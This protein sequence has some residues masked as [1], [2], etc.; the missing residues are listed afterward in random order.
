MENGHERRGTHVFRFLEIPVEPLNLV[1]EILLT[2][3]WDS[4]DPIFHAVD[5]PEMQRCRRFTEYW[6]TWAW[7]LTDAKKENKNRNTMQLRSAARDSIALDQHSA[8]KPS[9]LQ[10]ENGH[11]LREKRVLA[12][13]WEIWP[14]KADAAPMVFALW[15]G[16]L[17][18]Q[19]ISYW[20]C[21]ISRSLRCNWRH[22]WICQLLLNFKYWRPTMSEVIGR[23]CSA[24]W[25]PNTV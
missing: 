25:V 1:Y 12:R 3:D 11:T 24:I 23:R 4:N 16:L 19:T 21:D 22:C 10:W 2:N 13:Y 14:P 8:W 9:D 6:P 20:V 17:T 7:Q 15:L 18:Y 5:F